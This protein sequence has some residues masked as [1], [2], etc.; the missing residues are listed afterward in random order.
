MRPPSSI[1]VV[2]RLPEA[3]MQ[4]LSQLGDTVLLEH[5]TQIEGCDVVQRQ[6][7]A[8]AALDHAAVARGHGL[9]HD[10]GAARCRKN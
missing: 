5:Q 6:G 8:E 2:R 9:D 10:R 1:A 3:F 7:G 4:G